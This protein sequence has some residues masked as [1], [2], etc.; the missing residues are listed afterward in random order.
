LLFF[1]SLRL[2][3]KLEIIHINQIDTRTIELFWKINETI[4]QNLHAIQIQY[5][6]NHPK[7]SWITVNDIYNRSMQHA[8][9]N[10]LQQEQVYKF[11]LIGFDAHGK[12]LVISAAK[13][14]ALQSSN[15]PSHSPIPDITDAW[16]TNDGQIH[17]K[18]Q[19]C[20]HTD[21]HLSIDTA[22]Y[23]HRLAIECLR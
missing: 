8:I 22:N 1:S 15:Q 11:R 17:V 12:Q 6:L 21:I 3:F 18:W 4:E 23:C 5:R 10:E 20:A 9:V 19:V 7:T 13:R 14:F 16:V 2:V